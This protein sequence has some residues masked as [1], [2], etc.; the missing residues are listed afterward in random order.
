LEA[1]HPAGLSTDGFGQP[2]MQ[3]GI[4]MTLPDFARALAPAAMAEEVD[5]GHSLGLHMWGD[6]L[7]DAREIAADLYPEP[8]AEVAQKLVYGNRAITYMQKGAGEVLAAGTRGWVHGLK[9]GDP[10]IERVTKNV[11]GRFTSLNSIRTRSAKSCRTLTSCVSFFFDTAPRQPDVRFAEPAG[12][13]GVKGQAARPTSGR[14]DGGDRQEQSAL[15]TL[16]HLQSIVDLDVEM[17]HCVLD[18]P[19]PEQELN[20]AEV[21]CCP[22]DQ[23]RLGSAQRMCPVLARISA[24]HQ[25]P[26]FHDPR[27][28][29]RV[30]ML[31]VGM[32]VGKEKVG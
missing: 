11:M 20:G 16:R 19:V 17:P 28:L 21:L 31:R 22:I 26:A 7:A 5:H 32:A 14:R 25:H 29:P 4:S 9:G 27:I 18:F 30:Q 12:R 2:L 23:R 8:T 3:G 24:D 1:E 6:A 13:R 10:F 15:D